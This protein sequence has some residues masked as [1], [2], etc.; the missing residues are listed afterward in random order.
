M[1]DLALISVF[2][3]HLLYIDYSSP[4]C[5]IGVL[6]YDCVLPGSEWILDWHIVKRSSKADLR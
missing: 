2:I 4:Q 1:W 3:N 5:G 6:Q